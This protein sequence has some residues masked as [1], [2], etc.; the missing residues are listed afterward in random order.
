MSGSKLVKFADAVIN[1]TDSPI[2]MYLESVGSIWT[3]AP[4]RLDFKLPSRPESM[5][6]VTVYYVVDADTLVWLRRSG[7]SLSDIAL[8]VS[9]GMGRD[10]KEISHL[11]W[12]ENMC[13]TVRFSGGYSMYH[14][15]S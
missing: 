12:A 7:R 14:G 9:R 5:G 2:S 8:V 3:F 1:L 6:C 15:V 11:V 4:Q 10:G 13:M